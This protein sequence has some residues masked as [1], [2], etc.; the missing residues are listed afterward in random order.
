MKQTF[1]DEYEKFAPH[2]RLPYVQVIAY[3]T[4]SSPGGWDLL[5]QIIPDYIFADEAHCLRHVGSARTRRL[6]R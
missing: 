1:L 6:L 2:F 3:S 5:N 4:L